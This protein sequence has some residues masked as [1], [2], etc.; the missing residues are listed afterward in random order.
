L[1]SAGRF[2]SHNQL[3][4]CLSPVYA[5]YCELGWV[6]DSPSCAAYH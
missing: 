4:E 6:N 3:A 5:V 1:T 2:G